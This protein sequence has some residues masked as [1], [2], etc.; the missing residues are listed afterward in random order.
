MIANRFCILFLCVSAGIVT[1]ACGG[2]RG[3]S[4]R[5]Y[6]RYAAVTRARSPEAVEF[7]VISGIDVDSHGNVY[8]ADRTDVVVLT[9]DLQP[10]R[11]LGR[12]G[13]GPGEFKRVN[14]VR[15]LPHDSVLAFDAGVSRVTVFAPVAERAAYTIDFAGP[16]QFFPYAVQRVSD[17]GFLGVYRAAYGDARMGGHPGQRVEVMRLL[18]PDA[19]LRQDSGLKFPEYEAVDLDGPMRGTIFSPWGRQTLVAV[20]GDRVYTAW[21]GE[22]LVEVHSTTGKHLATI[23][24]DGPFPER[25]ITSAEFDSVASETVKGLPLPLEPVRRALEKSGKRT[26]PLLQDLLVDDA[27]VVWLAVTGE[28]GEGVHWI[29]VDERGRRVAAFDVPDRVRIHLIR[30]RAAYGVQLDDDDVPHVVIYDLKPQPT[31]TQERT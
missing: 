30:G 14:S 10:L 18:N 27:G 15:V 7:S 29:G 11:R 5:E 23:R 8:V 19:S 6:P 31:R 12:E 26:W 25:P 20:H 28:R 4:A 24:A 3:N 1:S 16:A 13:K 2:E 22:P 17:G 9:P 21:S